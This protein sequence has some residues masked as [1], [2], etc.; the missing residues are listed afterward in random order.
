MCACSNSCQY[1]QYTSIYLTGIGLAGYRIALFESHLLSD[2]RINLI[3]CLLIS[4]KKFQ[5]ACLCTCRSLR[6][7]QL[8]RAQYIVQI[9]QIHRKFLNPESCSLTN[10]C[11]LCRLEMSKRQCWL[12]FIL[13][14]KI[15]QLCNHIHQLGTHQLQCFMHHDNIGIIPYIT[16][17]CSQVNDSLCLRALLPICIYM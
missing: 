17:S 12:G 10:C 16:G 4:I 15:C 7:K 1:I 13:I 6:A 9:F 8:Q 3:N 14:C 5:E 2:H 11:R